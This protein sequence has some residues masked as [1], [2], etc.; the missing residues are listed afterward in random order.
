MKPAKVLLQIQSF[1]KPIG[2]WIYSSG[3]ALGIW[4]VT[5]MNN[6]STFILSSE[7]VPKQAEHFGVYGVRVRNYA[8]STDIKVKVYQSGNM[9]LLVIAF[10]MSI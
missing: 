9:S 8:G 1:E 2:M 4:G 7:I 10:L 6:S 5:R 3:G